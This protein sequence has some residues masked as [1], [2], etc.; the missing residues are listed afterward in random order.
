MSRVC[1]EFSLEKYH[2]DNIMVPLC[3]QPHF[4]F[5]FIF[6]RDEIFPLSNPLH[7]ISRESTNKGGKKS[8]SISEYEYFFFASWLITVDTV[9]ILT[10]FN[11]RADSLISGFGHEP[12]LNWLH[13]S[14]CVKL[15]LSIVSIHGGT[16]SLKW[17]HVSLLF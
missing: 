17:T 7:A 12:L 1:A 15:Y 14:F 16:L 4:H 9:K 11:T 6:H 8:W 5:Q 13:L 2:G 3:I 10:G